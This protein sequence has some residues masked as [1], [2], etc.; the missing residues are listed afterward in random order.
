MINTRP[1]REQ[2]YDFLKKEMQNGGLGD[3]DF[4]NTASISKTLG[5]SKTP[6]RD[7]LIQLEAE[8]FVSIFPRRGIKVKKVT[9]KDIEEYYE[10]IGSLEATVIRNVFQKLDSSHTERMT[11]LNKEQLVAIE[12]KDF[13]RYYHLNLKF[14]N[15][16]MDL[17]N[18]RTL[19]AAVTPLKQ[20]LYD[21]PRRNYVKEWELHHLDEHDEFIR[22]INDG[23]VQGA[24]H[25]MQ[26]RHWS[27]E[28]H[29][30]YFTQFYELK[31]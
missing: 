7:A 9:L 29:Q 10:L 14:H 17:S 18:N 27:F 12:N 15:V 16:F 13:D 5:I 1:L 22:M 26:H 4:I 23:D 19:K 2:I 6:L 30:K 8:G 21:F 25:I 24:A 31:D 3:D 20:R 28:V 11:Q